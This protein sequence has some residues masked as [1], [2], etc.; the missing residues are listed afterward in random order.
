M[1]GI[2]TLIDERVRKYLSNSPYIVSVPCVVKAL[3]NNELVEVELVSNK[4]RYTVPNWS[5][6]PVEVGEN[7]QLFYKGNILTEQTA[8]VGASLNKGGAQSSYVQANVTIGTLLIIERD[9]AVVDFVNGEESVL[10]G[11]NAVIQGDSEN[12][13]CGEFDI[14][15]DEVLQ[16]YTAMFSI[17]A[18]GHTTC[19]FTIPMTLESGD[20]EIKIKG[21]GDYATITKI[22]AYVWGDVKSSETPIQPTGDGDYRFITDNDNS[23]SLYYI[24]EKQ[25][26]K[27]PLTLGNKPLNTI[28]STTFTDSN[29]KTVFI[30]DGVERIE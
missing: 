29:V 12:V 20:H 16:D 1:E 19:S 11:F 23:Y 14:Y 22:N 5:G 21:S 24:G 2:F 28:E 26:I 30:Q 3:G 8:Y 27:T 6:S 13:G 4:A 17:V 18:D 25:N 10:L 9:V 15:I 7:V